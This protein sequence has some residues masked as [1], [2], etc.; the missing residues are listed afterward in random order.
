M[1][2]SALQQ[3][4]IAA[5]TA[6][7]LV[8]PV[9]P[10]LLIPTTGFSAS[11]THEQILDQGRRG[12]NSM[13]YRAIQGVIHQ[14]L[15]LE[16]HVT[17][18]TIVQHPS[19]AHWINNLLETGTY[20]PA[21]VGV[22]G[23]F[24]HQFILGSTKEYFTLEEKLFGDTNDRRFAGVRCN[25]LVIRFNSG[26][27]ALT[28]TASLQ[29]QVVSKVTVQAV[30]DVQLD[31][32]EGW[33]A[34]LEIN[35]VTVT[36]LISAE[37]TLRRSANRVFTGQNLQTFNDLLFG[38]LEVLCSLVFDYTNVADV[39]LFR[40]KTQGTLGVT[41][42]SGTVDTATERAFFIGG[43]LFDFGDGPAEIDSSGDTVTVALTCRGLHSTGIATFN[44]IGTSEATLPAQNGPI[45]VEIRQL[46]TTEL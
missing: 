22:T 34:Q 23:V 20:T 1:T 5:A 25:E 32:F 28:Y 9:N 33:K 12:L 39:D 41:F 3:I 38:P 24:K 37:W 6:G 17:E 11:E 30:T 4:G 44:P 35:G 27:G 18:V 10:T 13:D 14:E 43:R 7:Q 21:Q 46:I 8:T 40:D 29:S 15:T 31:P 45:I 2:Q 26:E 42:R 16:G 19:V 36:R